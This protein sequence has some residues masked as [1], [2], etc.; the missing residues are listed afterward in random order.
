[1]V[2]RN[3]GKCIRIYRPGEGT[4]GDTSVGEGLLDHH[5]FDYSISNAGSLQ[6]LKGSVWAAVVR[7]Y[8][9]VA[10]EALRR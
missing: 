6:D 3:G 5:T 10:A 8:G 1:M 9:P 7:L 4:R 2:K